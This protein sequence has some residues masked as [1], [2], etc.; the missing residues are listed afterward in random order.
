MRRPGQQRSFGRAPVAASTRVTG[1]HE[2]RFR[3][4]AA[5]SAGAPPPASKHWEDLP[6][7]NRPLLTGRWLCQSTSDHRQRRASAI[8]WKHTPNPTP[9][10]LRPPP[11]PAQSLA[12]ERFAEKRASGSRP[13]QALAPSA[14]DFPTAEIRAHQSARARTASR[15]QAAHLRFDGDWVVRVPGAFAGK[16]AR[17]ERRLRQ[18]SGCRVPV[19][20]RLARCRVLD[21][22][23]E[24]VSCI[25]FVPS[26]TCLTSPRS[27]PRSTRASAGS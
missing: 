14:A 27:S 8:A 21:Q 19:D 10:A 23:E 4:Q 9:L 20:E 1:H 25:G 5:C 7:S 24:Q 12:H 11:R 6:L 17:G 18:P 13:R 15:H 2:Y 3:S 16:R 22:D 26:R